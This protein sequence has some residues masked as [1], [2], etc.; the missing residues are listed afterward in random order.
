MS[1]ESQGVGEVCPKC[2]ELFNLL[3]RGD[4]YEAILDTAWRAHRKGRWCGV[5]LTDPSCL[6]DKE[7][8]L[9]NNVATSRTRGYYL[10]VRPVEDLIIIA[11][12]RQSHKN[13]YQVLQYLELVLRDNEVAVLIAWKGCIAYDMI[14]I[15]PDLSDDHGPRA[16]E[17]DDTVDEEFMRFQ[18]LSRKEPMLK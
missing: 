13:S 3:I 14:T 7:S 8:R 6:P 12:P 17:C 5:L 1:D 4:V 18:L 16:V 15:D 10:D 9:L 11:S 2:Q